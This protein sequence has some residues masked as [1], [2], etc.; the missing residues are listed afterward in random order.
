LTRADTSDHES[1]S[2]EDGVPAGSTAAE[3]VTPK[4]GSSSKE[5]AFRDMFIIN[6]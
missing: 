1:A 6:D 5:N 3:E 4:G 2:A